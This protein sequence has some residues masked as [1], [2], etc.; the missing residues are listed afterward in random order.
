LFHD[1][2]PLLF[3]SGIRFDVSA[4]V[5]VNCVFIILFLLPVPFREK[6]GYQT[7]LKIIFIATN[8]IAL[9]A[10]CID[11]AYY[12]FTLKRTTADVFSWIGAGG[13][14]VR[15]IPQLLKDYWFVILIWAAMV[16]LIVKMYKRIVRESITNFSLKETIV[17]LAFIG[18]CVVGYRG[19]I[20]LRPIGII[21]AS[22]YT[23]SENIPLVIN[24]PFAIIKTYDFEELEDKKYMVDAKA[25]EI[26][27]PI[28]SFSATT[29]PR[30][31]NV[32]LI[33]MESF[34]KEYI[35]NLSHNKTYTP[36]LDSLIGQSLVFENAFANGKK[37]IEGI[38]A[39]V[40]SIPT[41]MNEAY[42]TSVYGSNKIN[43]L[44]SIL[45]TEGYSTAFYHGGTNGT[46]SFDA[47]TKLAGFD[48]YVGRTEY[49]NE[50]DYDGNWGIWDEEFFQFTAKEISKKKE[51]FFATIFSLTSHHPFP[52]PEKYKTKF[53]EGTLPI[54]KSISY[55]DYSL[56]KFFETCSKQKWFDSTLF[57]ITA[58]H[59]GISEGDFYSNH[60]GNN[61]I[62][63][64][65]YMHNSN[66]KGKNE[67]TA[68]HAD[69]M[70]TLLDYL[71]IQQNYFSFGENLLDSTAKHFSIC[72]SSNLYHFISSGNVL[73]FDG[74]KSIALYNFANDS[75]LKTNLVEKEKT[76]KEEMEIELKAIIQQYN[77]SLINNKMT[78]K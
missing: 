68:Q 76:K 56:Q 2:S 25:K 27:N 28:H 75:L 71:K 14:T 24:T 67:T 29:N 46:M 65:F 39:I 40:A 12:R 35:G 74:E 45:K 8:S 26:F 32:M 1:A 21:N 61:A 57:V 41:L 43:S 48:D 30:K 51:P 44:A 7:L 3:L 66:L 33:I 59:T 34:S 50:K 37:S 18:V 42:I 72:Y 38:P 36:F 53:P 19:G 58:D 60:V 20:Q 69:I 47:F 70:P 10:N 78:P 31:L 13:D 17:S 5:V 77:S 49:N 23:S 6:K 52:V 73:Q 62:P 11:F 4:I 54:H 9:F 22:E 55:S 16:W 15:L 63:L 64:L